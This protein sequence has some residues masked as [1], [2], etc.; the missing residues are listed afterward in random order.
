M[1]SREATR[2]AI[3]EAGYACLARYGAER[4]SVE[5]VAQAAGISRATMYRYFPG[6]RDE[7]LLEVVRYEYHQFF[8]RLYDAVKD[9]ETLEEVIERG[10]L[11]GHR[12]IEEHEVLQM[13]LRVEPAALESALLVESAPTRAQVA[14]FLLVYLER[15]ELA[16][17]VDP[18]AAASYL[19]RL[20][21]SYMQAPGQWD[22][23][24]PDEV[25][26][27]VR[28]ELLAG[29]VPPASLTVRQI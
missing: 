12:A 21:L 20:V 27:L 29:I 26:R 24:N 1:A 19:A 4:M 7:L 2:Q 15:H 5:D 16:D 23:S 13:M 18:R 25:A 14:D 17:G 6:G 28:S 9:C 22:L 8:L 3:V 10:L 11:V